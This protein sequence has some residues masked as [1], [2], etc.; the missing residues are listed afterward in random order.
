MSH[1]EETRLL[2]LVER[3]PG[4]LDTRMLADHVGLPV[5]PVA[6]WVQMARARRRIEL[7]EFGRLVPLAA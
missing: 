1:Y 3:L 2:S 5:P 7:D 6:S 4:R